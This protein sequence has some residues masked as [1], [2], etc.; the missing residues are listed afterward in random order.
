MTDVAKRLGELWKQASVADKQPFVVS[1]ALS[2]VHG[3]HD[4]HGMCVGARVL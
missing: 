1:E 4:H 2:V 3:R